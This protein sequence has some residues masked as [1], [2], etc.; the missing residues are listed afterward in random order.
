MGSPP[1]STTS[2]LLQADTPLNP[3]PGLR[4]ED[5]TFSGQFGVPLLDV[6]QL[7]IKCRRVQSVQ[8]TS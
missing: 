7:L 1:M 8:P 6:M 2:H 3:K 4:E 5:E